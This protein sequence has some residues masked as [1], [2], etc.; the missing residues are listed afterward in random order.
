[1]EAH[2]DFLDPVP[3]K[4]RGFH[5]TLYALN[6]LYRAGFSL[7]SPDR[8][9]DDAS[10]ST[11]LHVDRVVSGS[12]L[13]ALDRLGVRLISEA[14]PGG[15]LLPF[16]LL[17]G[18]P[19]S[20]AVPKWYDQ[21][22]EAPWNVIRVQR[23]PPP[24]SAPSSPLSSP[25]RGTVIFFTDGSKKGFIQSFSS[26]STVPLPGWSPIPDTPFF[27]LGW[28]VEVFGAEEPSIN[29]MELMAVVVTLE[30]CGDLDV[31]IYSDSSYVTSHLP[32]S[33]TRRLV[34][35]QDRA[36][37]LRFQAALDRRTSL[38][39]STSILKCA[40]HGKDP[41]QDPSIT[42]GNSVADS[43]AKALLSSTHGAAF[44]LPEGDLP[45]SLLFR[46]A[47]VSGDPRRFIRRSFEKRALDRVSGLSREG[48][49]LSLSEEESRI[50]NAQSL[51]LALNPNFLLGRGL[52]GS[53]GTILGIRTE[54]LPFP[55]RNHS[56]D[57][58]VMSF[59]SPSLDGVKTCHYCGD[60]PADLWHLIG[61]AA[62][63]PLLLPVR[64][65]VALLLGGLHVLTADPLPS[66][67]SSVKGWLSSLPERGGAPPPPLILADLLREPG[68]SA[69]PEGFDPTKSSFL[70]T[71]ASTAFSFRRLSP[72]F[73][74]ALFIPAGRVPYPDLPLSFL[75]FPV[76]LLAHRDLPAL[77]PDSIP[78]L[79][80]TLDSCI[81][82]GCFGLSLQW[83]RKSFSLEHPPLNT[84]ELL[85]S[86][87]LLPLLPTRPERGR[88]HS[89]FSWMGLLPYPLPRALS[90]LFPPDAKG[91][92]NSFFIPNF[93]ATV[94]AGVISCWRSYRSIGRNVNRLYRMRHLALKEG[95]RPP[96]WKPIFAPLPPSHLLPRPAR[97]A[98]YVRSVALSSGLDLSHDGFETAARMAG[99]PPPDRIPVILSLLRLQ[100][101]GVSSPGRDPDRVRKWFPRQLDTEEGLPSSYA[102]DPLFPF[103]RRSSAPASPAPP[104][105]SPSPPSSPIP[106][107]SP[108]PTRGP[109]WGLIDPDRGGDIP[110]SPVPRDL[111]R[112]NWPLYQRTVDTVLDSFRPHCP[113][114]VAILD[115]TAFWYVAGEEYSQTLAI[116]WALL[117]LSSDKVV[118]PC[119]L[120]HHW[121]LLILTRRT[122]I[123]S[124]ISVLNSYGNLGSRTCVTAWFRFLRSSIPSL[125]GW[126]LSWTSAPV[127]CPQQPSGSQECGPFLLYNAAAVLQPAISSRPWPPPR[128]MRRRLANLL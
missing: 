19:E 77:G 104:P 109:L 89:S 66:F 42:E 27:R 83:R 7:S 14:A 21:L 47:R 44:Y 81:L 52:L 63:S 25:H 72:L 80:S 53:M 6:L 54:S 15:S 34:R 10:L 93:L 125:I 24:E 112:D 5:F 124:T 103:A 50:F 94:L 119:C 4:D 99:V 46:G 113:S 70:L 110:S 56:E 84:D 95:K 8:P 60:S 105:R 98:A 82:G 23:A 64:H 69:F 59:F 48:G 106:P 97:L 61:C 43:E 3:R 45:Y 128:E 49:I 41:D 86:F 115:S 36:L 39:L 107:P 79:I 85:A 87:G 67:Y 9:E 120:G 31:V 30:K 2:P 127:P 96:P 108:P 65:S 122:G 114:G 92:I 102:P 22:A 76:V 68:R 116:R 57:P 11:N 126:P 33:S 75:P 29:T 35:S 51:S 100:S 40:S 62:S 117:I 101:L 1:M 28:K 90:S 18:R 73:R 74:P 58:S 55:N 111:L 71:S 13:Q 32:P 88:W 20:V 16:H 78:S 26:I 123:S 37:W 17:S 12:L 118:I 91:L 121:V 38:S